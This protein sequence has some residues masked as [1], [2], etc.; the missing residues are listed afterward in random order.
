MQLAW[1]LRYQVGECRKA[2][3]YGIRTIID[4]YHRSQTVTRSRLNN[5]SDRLRGHCQP[6]MEDSV[7][8]YH[9]ITELALQLTL[10]AACNT[11]SQT[12]QII[13]TGL[14]QDFIALNSF[15][16]C[17]TKVAT[18]SHNQRMFQ[19]A[20]AP[21]ARIQ[22]RLC[23]RGRGHA[24]TQPHNCGNDN[25]IT[26]CS[27]E[28]RI[29]SLLALASHP[30]PPQAPQAHHHYPS[31]TSLAKLLTLSVARQKAVPLIRQPAACKLVLLVNP[32]L[33]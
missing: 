25:P 5:D 10:Q 12:S 33:C 7:L 13:A 18:T 16:I 1:Q 17:L 19:K 29:P 24:C 31:Q 22:L 23:S 3:D 8:D 6:S 30:D 28:S 27:C 4:P 32:R 11:S 21:C 20:E 15:T 2:A 9:I 14:P 26:Q